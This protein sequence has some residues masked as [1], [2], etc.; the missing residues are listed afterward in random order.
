MKSDST[1]TLCFAAAAIAS[2][3]LAGTRN[4]I[5]CSILRAR[6]SL[7]LMQS[8]R[9][10]KYERRTRSAMLKLRVLGI[11]RTLPI[12]TVADTGAKKPGQGLGVDWVES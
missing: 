8:A 2:D 11:G 9:G 12:L 10:C 3:R 4:C 1:D 7:V 5:S 6:P